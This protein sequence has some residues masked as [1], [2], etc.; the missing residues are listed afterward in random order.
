MVAFVY[1]REGV[2]F[3]HWPYIKSHMFLFS[4]RQHCQCLEDGDNEHF[5]KYLLDREK[6]NFNNFPHYFEKQIENE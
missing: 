1:D 6:A 4:F 2:L 3:W 5:K